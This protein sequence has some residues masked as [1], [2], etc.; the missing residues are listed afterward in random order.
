MRKLIFS[1]SLFLA[2][3]PS[4]LIAD[5]ITGYVS[6]AHCGAAH[7]AV[8]AAN[9]KCVDKCLQGGADPVLI[10]NGKVMKFDGNSKDKAKAFAGQNVKIDGTLDGHTVK[11]NSI[12]KAQ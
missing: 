10:S 7:N 12:D 4:A 6:D 3:A 1:C 2:L 11:I 5:E 8:S 9:T